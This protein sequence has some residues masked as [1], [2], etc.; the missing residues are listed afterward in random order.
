MHTSF[1]QCSRPRGGKSNTGFPQQEA[2]TAT[3]RA[4]SAIAG[5]KKERH[6]RDQLLPKQNQFSLKM[7]EVGP[8]IT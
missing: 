2:G 1:T 5:L 3:A 4:R 6:K 8:F 7:N